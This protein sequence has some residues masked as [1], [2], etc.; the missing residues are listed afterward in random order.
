MNDTRIL[1]VACAIALAAL[2]AS[3]AVA[4]ASVVASPAAA[5]I[6]DVSKSFY[7]PQA[8]SVSTPAEGA[9]AIQ[10]FRMCPNNDG[11]TSLPNK[12]RI[13]VVVRDVSGNGISGV[14]A[15][16]IAIVFNGGSPAQISGFG[17]DSVISNSRFN[18]TCPDLRVVDADAPTDASGTTYITFAGGDPANPGQTLLNG[19]LPAHRGRKWG[20]FD[21]ELPVYV[22]GFKLSGRITTESANGS[23]TLQI[24]SYDWT[25]GLG[26]AANQ[27]ESVSIA[28]L[29]GVVNAIP[30][31]T[32]PFRYWMDFDSDGDI[33]IQDLNLVTNHLNHDCDLPNNP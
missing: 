9:A 19:S 8:G 31:N 5:C 27:G 28:D 25:G 17:A 3:P 33:V 22:L 26:T 20:H 11:G 12:A 21:S 29:N 14:A 16:D 15:A 2:V 32:N 24:K 23:Y 4:L 30:G 7:V 10:H 13:K 18:A 6:P 1:P